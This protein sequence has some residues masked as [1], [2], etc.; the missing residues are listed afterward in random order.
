MEL[1]KVTVQPRE[2][3]IDH[4]FCIRLAPAMIASHMADSRSTGLLHPL[5]DILTHGQLAL[6]EGQAKQDVSILCPYRNIPRSQSTAFEQKVNWIGGRIPHGHCYQKRL[7]VTGADLGSRIPHGLAFCVVRRA[8]FRRL[9]PWICTCF[10][11]AS[12]TYGRR[13]S[14]SRRP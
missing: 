2:L 6:I 14:G 9:S 13:G 12:C 11:V 5:I 8:C 3:R 4:H 7:G 1:A 10:H